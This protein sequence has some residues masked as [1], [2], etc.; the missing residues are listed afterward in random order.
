MALKLADSATARCP[1]PRPGLAGVLLIRAPVIVAGLRQYFEFLWDRATP[2]T[3]TKRP[4]GPAQDS[5]TPALQNILELMAE[6]LP[7]AAIAAR[8]GVSISTARRHIA[9]IVKRLDASTRFAARRRRPP[10]RLD[11]LAKEGLPRQ[12]SPRRITAWT[13]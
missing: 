12:P 4:P 8:A 7:D 1:S 11:Q 5:L 2:F 9:A 10:A 6:G 13:A 3:T